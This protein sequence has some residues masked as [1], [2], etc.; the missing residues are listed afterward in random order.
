MSNHS[1]MHGIIATH[2]VITFEQ[3]SSRH[4]GVLP[5][6]WIRLLSMMNR[7]AIQHLKNECDI[8]WNRRHLRCYIIILLQS[9]PCMSD[10]LYDVQ[11]EQSW[12]IFVRRYRCSNYQYCLWYRRRKYVSFKIW[13]CNIEL[14]KFHGIKSFNYSFKEK[15]SDR[16]F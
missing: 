7:N 8:D 12:N 11:S 6:F 16:I 2:D 14:C 13:K 4:L 15:K 1:W 9:L 3:H 5:M 10:E